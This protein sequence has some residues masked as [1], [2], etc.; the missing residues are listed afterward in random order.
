MSATVLVR[1]VFCDTL[2]RVNVW[3]IA[4]GPRCADC[5]KPILLDRP[6]KTTDADFD[7]M[8]TEAGVPVLVD[9]WADWCGPCHAMAPVLDTF[10]ASHAGK[11]LV[12]KLDTDANPATQRRFN[13]RGIPT[14][15]LFRQGKELSRHSGVTDVKVLEDM[16]RQA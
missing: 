13:V 14:M 16:L 12:L 3:R 4:D 1:C 15:I 2:N 11:V 7:R 10:A 9:F 6:Q 5:K 8:T